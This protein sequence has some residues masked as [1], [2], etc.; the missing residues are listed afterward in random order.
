MLEDM[1]LESEQMDKI[2]DTLE[3]LGIDTVGEDYIPELPDDVE[4]TIEAIEELPEEEIV[5][6]NTMVDAFGTDD[7]DEVELDGPLPLEGDLE[8]LRAQNG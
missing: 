1:D 3:N 8:G 2:Y 5:D 4:P 6:P 7:A